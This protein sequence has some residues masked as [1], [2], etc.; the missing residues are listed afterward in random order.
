MVGERALSDKQCPEAGFDVI[1]FDFSQCIIT[2][3]P[4]VLSVPLAARSKA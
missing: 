4:S 2:E 1:I 3:L